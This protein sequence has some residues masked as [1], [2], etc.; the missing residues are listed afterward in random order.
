MAQ[1]AAVVGNGGFSTTMASFAAGVPQVVV[2]LFAFDQHVNAD[3]VAAVGA[4][5]HLAEGLHHPES[6]GDAVVVV[7]GQPSFRA[8][9]QRIA[10]QIAA[11]PDVAAAVPVLE[12]VAA[13]QDA[14]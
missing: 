1:A 11:L 6:I 13:G 7:L 14:W 10:R 3:R 5:I 12:A 2:P 9:A 8:S 4:G